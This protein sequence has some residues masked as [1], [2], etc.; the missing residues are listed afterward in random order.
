MGLLR[1]KYIELLLNK[2]IYPKKK[3]LFISYDK[4]NK[5][6]IKDLVNKAKEIGYEKILLDEVDIFIEHKLL[7][8]L[9]VEEIKDCNYFKKDIWNKAI[10][11]DC[12]FLLSTTSFPNILDDIESE[13]INVANELKMQSQK[14]Y[15]DCVMN[16]SISWTIFGLPNKVWAENLFLN[17]VN[18]YEKL[19]KLIY[20]F[21]LIDENNV[22][23]NWDKY[24]NIENKKTNYLNNLKIEKLILKNKYGTHLSMSLADDYIFRSLEN[25][26]CIENMP[27]YSIWTTPH[28]YKIYGVVYGTMPI[29]YRGNYINNY[30]FKFNDGKVIEYNAEVGKEYLDEFF[31]RDENNIYLGEIAVIDYNSPISISNLV[32]NNNLFDENF[33]THLALGSAYKNTIKSGTNMNL[34]ELDNKGLNISSEHMDFTIGSEDLSIVIITEDNKE[35][36]I[37]KDGNFDYRLIEEISPFKK[38]MYSKHISI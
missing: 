35:I 28:K 3:N 13:K 12:A 17:D 22:L 20:S 32:F 8:D 29:T 14:R 9:S 33:S 1:E 27:T 15:F 34:E 26:H 19:E 38:L 10:E 2:C 5:N 24:I 30:W 31:L 37:F 23:S 11:E 18:A 25:N 4:C 6:F 16:D 21:C 7:S 36:E